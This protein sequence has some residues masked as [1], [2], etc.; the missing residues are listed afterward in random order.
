MTIKAHGT[1]KKIFKMVD[2]KE[3]LATVVGEPKK[4]T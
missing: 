1:Q 2:L 4:N 3:M